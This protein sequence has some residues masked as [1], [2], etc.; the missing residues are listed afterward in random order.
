VQQ[1]DQHLRQGNRPAVIP[2]AA[3]RCLV[4]PPPVEVEVLRLC[5]S[6]PVEPA[7]LKAYITEYETSAFHAALTAL[8]V[9]LAD[10]ERTRSY[11]DADRS[12]DWR[13]ISAND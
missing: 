8:S 3:P 11:H 7:L 6:S 10:D 13:E 9:E 5:W 12:M 2:V 4:G 1:A